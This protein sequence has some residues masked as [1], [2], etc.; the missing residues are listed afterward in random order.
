MRIQSGTLG[1]AV[2]CLFVCFL[3]SDSIGEEIQ[4]PLNGIFVCSFSSFRRTVNV[5]GSSELKALLPL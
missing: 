1:I 3:T 4:L 2:L 5:T